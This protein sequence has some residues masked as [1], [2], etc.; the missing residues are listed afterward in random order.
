MALSVLSPRA[1]RRTVPAMPERL[2]VLVV[3]DQA[4][5]ASALSVLFDLHDIPCVAA[6]TPAEAARVVV[7]GG[8]GVVVQDMNFSPG[9]TSGD[10]GAALYRTIRGIDAEM[11]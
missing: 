9:A 3:E 4:A 5:V 7:K 1:A 10:E 11:P 6:K 8:V 2:K